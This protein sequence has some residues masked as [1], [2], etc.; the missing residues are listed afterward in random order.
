[1]WCMAVAVAVVPVV[2]ARRARRLKLAA[3]LAAR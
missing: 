2:L 3:V 1:L